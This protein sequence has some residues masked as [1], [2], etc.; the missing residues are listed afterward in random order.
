[1]ADMYFDK[2][3]PVNYLY[4]LHSGRQKY[5]KTFFS[6]FS[7]SN[8]FTKILNTNILTLILKYICMYAVQTVT[9]ISKMILQ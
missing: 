7:C 6:K 5:E 9:K 8:V 3:Y 2:K 1:M 4:P